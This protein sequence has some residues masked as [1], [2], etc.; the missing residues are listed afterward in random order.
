MPTTTISTALLNGWTYGSS[1][2]GR[3]GKPLQDV[4]H[5]SEHCS[6]DDSKVFA[7]LF[8]FS[9]GDL[10]CIHERYGEDIKGIYICIHN[11]T[12]AE[13]CLEALVS[14]SF[15][16]VLQNEVAPSSDIWQNLNVTE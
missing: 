6:L 2:Y 12:R 13:F 8:S 5:H 9:K 11:S 16:Q 4:G 10:S 1:F 15:E 3:L 7:F 14:P